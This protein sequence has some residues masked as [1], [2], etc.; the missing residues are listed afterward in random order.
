MTA[1]VVLSCDGHRHGQPCRGN[2]PTRQL[3]PFSARLNSPAWRSVFLPD[4][5]DGRWLDLCPSRGHDED[6]PADDRPGP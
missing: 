5:G 6:R 1:R 2:L 3:D 4:G